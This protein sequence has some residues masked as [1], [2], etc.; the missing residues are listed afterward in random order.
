[1]HRERVEEAMVNLVV[2]LMAVACVLTAIEVFEVAGLLVA[3]IV[4]LLR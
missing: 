2:T 3:A 1:V 4:V